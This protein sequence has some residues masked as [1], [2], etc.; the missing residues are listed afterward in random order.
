MCLLGILLLS[1]HNFVN[2]SWKHITC[3]FR[4]FL[5][6]SNTRGK[7][8]AQFDSRAYYFR[9]IFKRGDRLAVNC[10]RQSWKKKK[11]LLKLFQRQFTAISFQFISNLCLKTYSTVELGHRNVDYIIQFG[12][13]FQYTIWK[14]ILIYCIQCHGKNRILWKTQ[15]NI[16][17]TT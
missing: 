17:K 6:W 1:K 4:F 10:F 16:E 15:C 11:L 12:E 13:L 3:N 8:M 7:S 2:G 9:P 14:L 5:V